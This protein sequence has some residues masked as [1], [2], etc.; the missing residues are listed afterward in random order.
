ME[1]YNRNNYIQTNTESHPHETTFCLRLCEIHEFDPDLKKTTVLSFIVTQENIKIVIKKSISHTPENNLG[2][3]YIIPARA[4]HYLLPIICENGEEITIQMQGFGTHGELLLN[5][6]I[7]MYQN[8]PNHN[9]KVFTFFET[10]N[11]NIHKAL[12]AFRTC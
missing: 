2:K 7:C 5:E 3:S 10:L 4:F 8:M 9:E 6:R 11:E 1:T 12:C